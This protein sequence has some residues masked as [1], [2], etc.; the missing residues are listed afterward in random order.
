MRAVCVFAVEKK[1]QEAYW[2]KIHSSNSSNPLFLLL[3]KLTVANES[4]LRHGSD[5]HTKQIPKHTQQKMLN[6]PI[7]ELL[8]LNLAV[9][10]T[11]L[12]QKGTENIQ[13]YNTMKVVSFRGKFYKKKTCKTYERG[14]FLKPSKSSNVRTA[15]SGCRIVP[16]CPTGS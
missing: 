3:Q 5:T 1:P 10:V 12:R 9:G 6:I 16:A 7:F 15:V 11:V 14:A 8:M 2:S 13:I 4:K